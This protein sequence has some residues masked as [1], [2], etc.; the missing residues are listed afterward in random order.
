MKIRFL[1]GNAIKII[2]AITMLIDHI[3]FFL[4][5]KI[6]VFR[7][8]GRIAMPLFAF[9]VAEGCRYTRDRFRHFSLIAVLSVVYT[10]V[11]I[12]ANNTVYF[13]ILTTFSLSIV[14]IYA[15]QNLKKSVFGGMGAGIIALS[16]ATFIASVAFTYSFSR[17]KFWAGY[18][19]E[20][21][22]G[23]WG[24]MLPVFASLFDA[25]TLKLPRNARRLDSH[26]LRLIP[27][28]VGLALLCM[29]SVFGRN[30]WFAFLA[31]VP[32]LLYNGKKGRLPL[33]YFF[34]VFYP[35]HLGILYLIQAGFF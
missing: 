7:M 31:L 28:S 26:Y 13:S 25:R 35:A 22:Y 1:N 6:L 30:A 19:V 2:A 29:A 3:G 8:I 20:L 16:A 11:Y 24:C 21:D 14:M 23:F 34:Y 32:L 10:F 17:I 15:L 4:Y 9:L 12:T 33:K 5:P 27:F 18:K